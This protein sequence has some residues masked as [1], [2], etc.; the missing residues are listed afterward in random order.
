MHRKAIIMDNEEAQHTDVRGIDE[1][2]R[3]VQQP[4]GVIKRSICTP[5]QQKVAN[6]AFSREGA[7]DNGDEEDYPDY[8]G[9]FHKGLSHDHELGEVDKK[10]YETLRQALLNR[11]K[12]PAFENGISLYRDD[13]PY[14]RQ[15]VNP[16]PGFSGD[17][18][19]PNPKD[20]TIPPAPKVDSAEAAAEAVELYWMA[21]LRDVPFSQFH[22][23]K[24]VATACEEV[25]KLKEFRGPRDEKNRVTPAT[26]FR[27]S[28]CGDL[29]G[30]YV[31]QFLLKDIPLRLPDHQSAAEDDPAGRRLPD[32]LGGLARGW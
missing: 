10:A 3:P 29:V 14:G 19:G 9:N 32:P 16:Q 17:T 28:A 8:S 22:S 31:S 1:H 13:H 27:G 7:G 18:E 4:A 11:D 23:D 15:L 26:L 12:D 20:L 6:E 21:L 2:P 30:P 25:T 24:L 5:H